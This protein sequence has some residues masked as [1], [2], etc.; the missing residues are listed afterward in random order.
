MPDSIVNDDSVSPEDDPKEDM[1]G[2]L[3]PEN[4]TEVNN[5]QIIVKGEKNE[6]NMVRQSP[7]NESTLKAIQEEEHKCNFI[8]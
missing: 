1:P 2:S 8:S 5:F 7:L 6:M 3:Q 4:L